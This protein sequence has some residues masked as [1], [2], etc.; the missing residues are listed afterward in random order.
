MRLG[1]VDRTRAR[2]QGVMAAFARPSDRSLNYP[3]TPLRCEPRPPMLNV[4]LVVIDAMR[5]DALTPEVAPHT[6]ELAQGAIRFDKNFS[7]GNRR[8]PACSP[9]STGSPP[10][11]GMHSPASRGHR[12]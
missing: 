4:L 7:G 6:F 5:A 12:C 10:P 11:T 2:E 1:L 9:C 3:L 8:A